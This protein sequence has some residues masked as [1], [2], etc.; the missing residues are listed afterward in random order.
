VKPE[1]IRFN[2]DYLVGPKET[3]ALNL[4]DWCF[5]YEP[6]GL[7]TEGAWDAFKKERDSKLDAFVKSIRRGWQC[8]GFGMEII[9]NWD[10]TT[11]TH[12]QEGV[13]WFIEAR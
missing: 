7:T 12:S 4:M 1:R 8:V 10:P 5:D 11:N 3:E 13:Q 2:Q 6:K 9:W